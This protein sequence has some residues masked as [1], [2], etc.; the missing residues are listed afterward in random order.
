MSKLASILGVL[1]AL[2]ILLLSMIDFEKGHLVSAFFDWKGF[3]LVLGGTFAALLI[4]YPLS[5]MRCVAAGFSK[6]FSAE[7]DPP[8]KAIAT[9]VDLSRIAHKHGSLALEKQLDLIEDEFL[10]FG[11][12]EMMMYRKLS[13]IQNSLENHLNS[14][15]LRHLNCQEM[16]QNMASYAPAFGMMGTVMGLI[17]MMTS[18]MGSDPVM[19]GSGESEDLL[20]GL[21]QGMGLAL[22]TTFYGVMLA[23]FVF[24]P[25]AGKLKVLSD[26]EELKNEIFLQGILRLKAEQSP[27]LMQESLM[28]FLNERTKQKLAGL[29]L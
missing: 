20:G 21:L 15:Q 19:M 24:V 6:V 25:I 7:P 28:A 10:H 17:M 23:N 11:I 2:I 3:L 12:T 8:E 27:V 18:H 14:I 22:V 26:A 16:F 9:L 1:L 5:D 4:N 13:P 29:D